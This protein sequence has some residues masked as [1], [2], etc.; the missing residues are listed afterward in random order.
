M[1]ISL[2]EGLDS[3]VASS[4]HAKMIISLIIQTSWRLSDHTAVAQMPI[5]AHTATF[6]QHN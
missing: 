4:T 5:A 2:F 1:L 6:Y 3:M